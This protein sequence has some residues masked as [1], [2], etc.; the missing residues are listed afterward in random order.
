V[1]ATRNQI[2]RR[3]G[4]FSTLKKTGSL[5]KLLWPHLREHR[6]MLL[7]GIGLSGLLV[8]LR[9]LQ[10]WPLKFIIDTISGKGHHHI[11]WL[12][13]DRPLAV[14]L[15]SVAYISITFGTS[16]C[17]YAQR[18]LL[19]GLGNRVV[20]RFRNELYRHI[21]QL[22]LTYH[23]T[24]ETGELITRVV[25]DTARVRQGV[26]ALLVQIFQNLFLF[27]MTISVLVWINVT[28]AAIVALS[29]VLTVMMMGGRTRSIRRASAKSRKREGKL[30]SVIA[31]AMLGVR[32][33]QTFRPGNETS[34]RFDRQNTKSLKHEQKVRRLSEGLLLRVEVLLAIT[35]AMIL[36]VG[37]IGVEAGRLTPG[38]LVLFAAYTVAMYRPYRQ[39]ARQSA[40]V[41]RTFA[42][43]DR[44][45]TIMQ[46]PIF[47]PDRPGAIRATDV[48][49]DI[50]FESVSLKSAKKARGG[51]AKILDDL[52]LH[53]KPGSRVAV[54]GE[55]GSGKS[56]LLGLVPRLSDPSEGV[57]RIDG[58]DIREYEI[59]SLR[60]QMSVVFQGSVFFGLSVRD[61]ITLGQDDASA[62]DVEEVGRR[63]KMDKMI[64]NLPH[65][66][67]TIVKKGGRLFS[68]GERQRIAL[69][70]AMTRR[71]RIWLLDEPTTGLDREATAELIDTLLEETEGRTVL[72]VTHREEV[73]AVLDHVIV[74]S[75]G[76]LGFA[77][78]T[79]DYHHWLHGNAGGTSSPL[80][81]K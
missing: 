80:V 79:V 36:W 59:K 6:G 20:H 26:R 78:T 19:S 14:L 52:S 22:P 48:A 2:R 44:L 55:N 27:L 69:A 9:I 68:V 61:N 40:K 33:L 5:V 24:R 42:C 16:A 46:K 49:G 53:V 50:V 56:S 23:A 3:L 67:D 63:S 37:A 64:R 21:L 31:E 18:L 74:L 28:L 60:Q 41:G 10:P 58:R 7:A 25:Y 1:P 38:D 8:G 71:G 70:R 51:R 12:T 75:A 45:T 73:V 72:W 77:G 43:A 11:T 47:A 35:L 29:G 15:L 62:V 13:D 54:V 32:E 76:R 4:L 39:F 57:I 30:A 81:D 17:N 65:G 34:D 66:Y